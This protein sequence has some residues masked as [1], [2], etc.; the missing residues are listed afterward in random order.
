MNKILTLRGVDSYRKNEIKKNEEIEYTKIPDSFD[1]DTWPRNCN[2]NCYNCSLSIDGFPL[3]IPI[4]DRDEG[5]LER[6]NKTLMCSPSCVLKQ[7]LDLNL[8]LNFYLEGL[9][10][11]IQILTGKMIIHFDSTEDKLCLL[12]YGGSLTSTEFKNKI[13]ELNKEYFDNLDN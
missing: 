13:Y 12:M 6:Y 1:P 5:T 11:L 4:I 3:F 2:L 7:I 9:R 8:D 10:G